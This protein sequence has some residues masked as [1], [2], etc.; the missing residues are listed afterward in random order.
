MCRSF[1]NS[2]GAFGGPIAIS[3]MAHPSPQFIEASTSVK[4]CA[5]C[6]APLVAA[7][8]KTL[9]KGKLK[10]KTTSANYRAIIR[11]NNDHTVHDNNQTQPTKTTDTTNNQ[12][13]QKH[14]NQNSSNFGNQNQKHTQQ[15]D[16][17]NLL[18]IVQRASSA[19]CA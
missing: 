17:A 14:T 8:A 18:N 15:L 6:A 11:R 5:K 1:N 16:W 13:G 2:F 7:R 4:G 9:N 10:T 3:K 12:T 19:P